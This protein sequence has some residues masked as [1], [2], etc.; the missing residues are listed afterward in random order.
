VSYKFT[1]KE[2][3]FEIPEFGQIPAGALR[4]GR[5]GTDDMDRAFTILEE[6]IGI[7]SPALAALD[8][9]SINDFGTWLEG[10]T[11]GAPLGE[12]SGSSS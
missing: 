12:S 8:S 5:K 3:E 1:I 11:K 10:W 4:K 9:L 7:D 2:Q 6:A